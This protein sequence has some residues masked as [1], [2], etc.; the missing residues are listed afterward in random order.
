M[1]FRL[2]SERWLLLGSHDEFSE[3]FWLRRYPCATSE[4][5]GWLRKSR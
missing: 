2:E 5:G 4:L 3:V 1:R